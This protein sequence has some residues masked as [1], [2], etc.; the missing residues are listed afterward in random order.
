MATSSGAEGAI[1][2]PVVGNPGYRDEVRTDIEA[3]ATEPS[4]RP[5]VCQGPGCSALFFV[6][7]RCDRGQRYCSQRCRV[8]SR[9]Q[10]HR[11]ASGRYQRTEGGREAHR[12][13]QRSYRQ[14]HRDLRVTHQGPEPVITPIAIKLS[15]PPKC[16]CCGCHR[17]WI[18][19]YS[20]LGLPPRPR[21]RTRRSAKVRI[22]TFSD[23]R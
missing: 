16:A 18:D 1:I 5:R 2:R 4:L 17:H 22:P 7:S 3:T 20:P 11:A 14:R 10:Q 9:R 6:C 8:A 21:S 13:R 23:D 19:P 15:E 12:V